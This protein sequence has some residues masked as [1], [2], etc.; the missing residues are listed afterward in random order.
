[1]KILCLVLI[2]SLLFAGCYSQQ[3][4]TRNEPAPGDESA[5]FYLRDGSHVY[6][7]PGG[8]SR[9]EG[10]FLV[11][12]G[13][14]VVRTTH[15]RFDG[16]VPD[17]AIVKM[18]VNRFSPGRTVLAAVGGACVVAIIVGVI[19]FSNHQLLGNWNWM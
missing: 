15:I 10:G 16:E 17:S 9:V 8:H 2:L 12:G 6:A 3:E 19:Y 14:H 11:T 5:V 7:E 4:T 18:T 13:T 1:M